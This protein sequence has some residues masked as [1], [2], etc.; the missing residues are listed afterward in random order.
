MADASENQKSSEFYDILHHYAEWQSQVLR[1][2]FYP[3]K[4]VR[5]DITAPEG[6]EEKL[7]ALIQGDDE[8]ANSVVDETLSRQAELHA[9]AD[10]MFS[11][12]E[13]PDLATFETFLNL[14]ES[15]T[16]RVARFDIDSVLSDHGIDNATGLRTANVIIPDLE[17]ELERRARR[18]HPFSIVLAQVDKPDV[19]LLP[20]I[21]FSIDD[22]RIL[23]GDVTFQR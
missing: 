5:Q 6:L 2:V 1:A 14:Y 13:K 12:S 3:E 8:A 15:F 20:E 19:A 21:P 22:K 16:Q 9:A 11:V 17:R 18:G 4:I 23:L 7:R 10:A